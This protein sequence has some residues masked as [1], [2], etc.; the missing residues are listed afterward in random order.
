M[1]NPASYH[2][3]RHA[4]THYSKTRRPASPPVR[5]RRERPSCRAANKRDERAPPH[6]L[7]FLSA[8]SMPKY[9][10]NGEFTVDELIKLIPASLMAGIPNVAPA[11][12]PREM[13]L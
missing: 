1:L 6:E 12:K 8:V 7:C 10:N 3:G 2:T 5:T 13:G 9:D 4:L 11:E